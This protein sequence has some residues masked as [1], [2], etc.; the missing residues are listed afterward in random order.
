MT[1]K[2]IQFPRSVRV[3]QRVLIVAGNDLYPILE[4]MLEDSEFLPSNVE[5]Y[6]RLDQI[7]S[8]L[9]R[10][11]YGAVVVTNNGISCQHVLDFVHSIRKEFPRI[12]MLVLSGLAEPDFVDQAMSGGADRFLALP[13]NADDILVTLRLLLGPPKSLLIVEDTIELLTWLAQD[14]H[15]N[16]ADLRIDTARDGVEG[17]QRIDTH[18]PDL[19]ITNIVMPI[20]DGLEFLN[21]LRQRGI[22][23]PTLITSGYWKP[24]PA[25]D[26]RFIVE[27]IQEGRFSFLPKPFV[28]NDI[29]KW[30]ETVTN[31]GRRHRG[32]R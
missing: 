16:Y 18:L 4:Q 25:C 6:A 32:T 30:L 19:L 8:E 1:A 13:C 29:L 31:D 5:S 22:V 14:V 23:L 10:K 17:L 9:S 28:M 21:A 7:Y 26:E 2:I 15:E 12:R 20:M 24:G 27:R 3:K 11:A